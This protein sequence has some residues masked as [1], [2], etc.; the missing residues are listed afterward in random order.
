M[1]SLRALGRY[2]PERVVTND[3]LAAKLGVEASWIVEMSGI[4]QRRFAAPDETVVTMGVQAARECLVD[5]IGLLIASSG[6]AERRFPGPAAEIAKGLGL[7]SIPAIDLPMASAGGLFGIALAAQ[8]AP[9]YG[10]VLVVASE[11]MSRAVSGKETEILFGDGAGACLV[12]ASD[13]SPRIVDSVLHTDGEFAGALS[14]GFDSPLKMDG[15]TVILQASRK[16]P[17][18]IN[19]LLERNRLKPA[20]IV[21]YVLHQAN[22]NLIARVAKSLQVPG[23]RFFVNLQR[24]GNTSSASLL[25]ALSECKLSGPTVLAVFGAGLNWGAVLVA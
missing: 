2:L 13:D 23:D 12:S 16:I 9:S 20:D 21:S 18:A 5:G 25:I 3:A 6:T 7:N 19:E 15:R 11:I 24:Y 10:N 14:L 1:S 8:L 17:G 22:L 4:E